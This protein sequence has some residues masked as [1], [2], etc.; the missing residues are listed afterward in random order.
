MFL[1][2]QKEIDV[3]QRA[4]DIAY[5]TNTTLPALSRPITW[6][7]CPAYPGFPLKSQ[8]LLSFSF[9]SVCAFFILFFFFLFFSFLI[10]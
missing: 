6:I 3:L 4:I 2:F 8:E 5:V 7:F 1:S 9:C 10:L